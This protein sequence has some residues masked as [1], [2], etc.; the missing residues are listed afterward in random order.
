MASDWKQLVRPN[1]ISLF[2][3]LHA[4]NA[5]YASE[6]KARYVAARY[7]VEPKP[8]LKKV[9]ASLRKLARKTNPE[10]IRLR[11]LAKQIED[12]IV[13]MSMMEPT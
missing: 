4:I 6:C 12:A 10:L 5:R 1:V 3:R 8:D 11:A 2:D 7:A 13:D 9:Q